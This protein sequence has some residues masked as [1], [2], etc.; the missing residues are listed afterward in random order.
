VSDVKCHVDCEVFRRQA[1][2]AVTERPLVENVTTSVSQG[3]FV[4]RNSNNHVLYED[5]NRL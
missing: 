1:R 4:R 2:Y 3:H 5:S